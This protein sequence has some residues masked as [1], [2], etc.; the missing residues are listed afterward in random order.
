MLFDSWVAGK[1][2]MSG[3]SSE[4]PLG[5]Q[6]LYDSSH[7]LHVYSLVRLPLCTRLLP[8]ADF[9]PCIDTDL[10]AADGLADIYGN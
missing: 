1:L 6:E 10:G 5:W 8:M 2:C 4:A 3:V 9:A 7:P